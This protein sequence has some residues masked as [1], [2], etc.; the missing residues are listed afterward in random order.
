[1]FYKI[2]MRIVD[3][4]LSFTLLL[5]LSPIFLFLI[6]VLIITNNECPFFLQSR[7]G[8]N[9]QIFKIIKFKT[10]NNNTDINGVLLPDI[11]RL[12]KVG[13]YIRKSSLDEL[14]QLINVLK[15]EM[16]LV[17]PRPLRVHYL[18]LYTKEQSKRHQVKPGITG[19]AQV[20]GRNS[21]TWEEK[22][23]LDVWYVENQSFLLDIK[24]LFLTL[25]K[26]IKRD[27]IYQN[28]TKTMEPFKGAKLD[29]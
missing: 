20:N 25:Y 5:I 22:F 2:G 6:I 14:P 3:L 17:G 11:Y 23:E 1:M 9:E 4:T 15:G 21:I 16:S 29:G 7:P 27:G 26:V 19:W 18:P 8:I 12:T 28:E 13:K 24:I 10:M